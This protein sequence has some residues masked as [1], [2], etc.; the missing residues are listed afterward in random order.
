MPIR[1]TVNGVLFECDTVDE[2]LELGVGLINPKTGRLHRT[3]IRKARKTKPTDLF[4]NGG[5]LM[6]EALKESPEGV[7]SERLAEKLGVSTKSLPPMILGLRR[8]A[9]A[10]GL[11]FDELV[12][13]DKGYDKG[14]PISKYKLT[15]EGRKLATQ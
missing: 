14:K 6:L 15:E 3:G 5:K 11:D 12:I 9:A 10:M 4:S 7:T 2:A 13:R 8:K 1:I